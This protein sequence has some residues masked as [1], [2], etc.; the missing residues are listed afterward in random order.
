MYRNHTHTTTAPIKISLI[1]CSRKIAV[2][3]IVAA[4]DDDDERYEE[5]LNSFLKNTVLRLLYLLQAGN[6][7][8]ECV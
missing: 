6:A 3:V 7:I 1:F 5:K 2:V 4:D 8:V